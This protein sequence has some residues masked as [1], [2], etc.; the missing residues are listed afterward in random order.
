[1]LFIFKALHGLAPQYI[2]NRLS[3]LTL[4]TSSSLRSSNQLLLSAPLLL[5]R[6]EGDQVLSGVATRLWI[7]K[8]VFNVD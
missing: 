1:M 6:F 4:S 8:A 5:L 7:L 3:Y 2:S